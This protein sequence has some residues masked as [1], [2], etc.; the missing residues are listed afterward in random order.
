[1]RILVAEDD[2]SVCEMLAL[3]LQKEDYTYQFVSDGLAALQ[4]WES[5][6][7][8]LLLLDWML[9]KKSGVEV[10]KAIR[11]QD[12]RFPTIMLT[13]RTEE[14]DQ[15]LGLE[16]GADDYVLKP[17]RPLTLMARIRALLRRAYPLT[18]EATQ[19]VVEINE[20][21][22]EITISGKPMQGITPKEF[23]LIR[24]FA[25]YPKRVFSREELLDQ[26]WGMD[27]YVDERTVDAHI[28]RL[29]K[30][31]AS[32]EEVQIETVWGVGYR[33]LIQT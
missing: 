12:Q 11:N 16:F 3:F 1:M 5:G 15:V 25:R 29:R 28:N 18:N 2:A 31:L 19:Q 22:H 21:T 17:F 32:I 20:Q 10:C 26:V 6:D 30:K 9:P 4:E 7:Y 23:D 13:A 14:A 33:F 27:Y 8:D 24:L